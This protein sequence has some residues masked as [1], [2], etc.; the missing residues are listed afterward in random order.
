M[1]EVGLASNLVVALVHFFLGLFVLAR[2]PVVVLLDSSKLRFDVPQPAQLTV[3]DLRVFQ[4]IHI[5]GFFKGVLG[6][7][8]LQ[9]PVQILRLFEQRVYAVRGALVAAAVVLAA[10][11]PPAV[12]AAL[13]RI[14]AGRVFIGGVHS[15]V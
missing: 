2:E 12:A 9:P 10:V 15:R 14:A 11:V 6:P 7:L 1:V 3:V 8:L 13:L 5:S 4:L